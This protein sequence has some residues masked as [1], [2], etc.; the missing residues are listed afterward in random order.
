MKG[1]STRSTPRQRGSVEWPAQYEDMHTG[2]FDFNGSGSHRKIRTALHLD[3]DGR[4]DGFAIFKHDEKD[5]V[6]VDE[7]AAAHA[8]RHSSGCGRSWRR[9][10][11]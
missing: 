7:M 8:R 3:A 9:W 2:A 5:T 10:T 11:G 4:V 1:S 6:K